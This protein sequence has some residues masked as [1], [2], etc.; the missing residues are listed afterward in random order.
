MKTRNVALFIVLAAIALF[1]VACDFS[2]STANIA[3]AF[4]AADHD[5]TQPTTM[6]AQDAVFYAIVDLANAPEDTTVKVVWFAV[7]AENTDPELLI[8]E[9][10]ITSSDGRLYFNLTNAPGQLWPLGQYRVD[11]YL[12]EEL[13]TSLEFEV[14]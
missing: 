14:Q 1:A 11:I 5:G 4:M 10:T 3:N 9:V 13:N 12:N 6:F 8:D 7:D 2:F